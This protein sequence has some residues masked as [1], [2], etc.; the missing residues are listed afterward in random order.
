MKVVEM[1]Y[2]WNVRAKRRL[3]VLLFM[4]AFQSGEIVVA[5]EK[6]T[7][8]SEAGVQELISKTVSVLLKHWEG[9]ATEA[10]FLASLKELESSRTNPSDIL[11]QFVLYRAKVGDEK[12]LGAATIIGH[13]L[14]EE[15]SDTEMLNALVP[16][17]V[18]KDPVVRKEAQDSIDGIPS[19][20]G[21]IKGAYYQSFEAYLKATKENPS[22]ILVKYM[23]HRKADA[24]LSSM[25]NVYLDK[26]DA[27]ALVAQIKTEDEAQAIARLSKRSEWWAQ[28][29]A[30]VKMKQNPKLRDDEVIEQLQKSKNPVVSATIQEIEGEKK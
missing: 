16:L 7:I 12:H 10:D 4:C 11:P 6:Q 5:G 13:L 8:E 26:D 20:H 24:A 29:Y 2:I 1:N 21:D 9:Q 19:R 14:F 30:A 28:L 27:K 18:V 15:I 3:L 23:Y 22:E 17:L 25:A